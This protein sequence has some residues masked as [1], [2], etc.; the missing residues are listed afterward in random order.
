MPPL[1]FFERLMTRAATWRS[2]F[3]QLYRLTRPESGDTIN[4]LAS[5]ASKS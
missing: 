2:Q 5:M 4:E 1:R 3:G